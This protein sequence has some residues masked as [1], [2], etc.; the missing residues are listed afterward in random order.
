MGQTALFVYRC[1]RHE[2]AV[3]RASWHSDREAESA[4]T[5]RGRPRDRGRDSGRIQQR[6]HGSGRV[7]RDPR[8]SAFRCAGAASRARRRRRSV[9][10]RLHWDYRASAK[11][12]MQYLDNH[13]L[14]G[15]AALESG[16]VTGLR[17]LRVR[18][19]QGRDWRRVCDAGLNPEL[20][21]PSDGARARRAR[22]KRRC[23][24]TCLKPS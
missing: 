15:Y 18:G 21:P 13:M 16:Q 14:P 17:L 8:S 24:G 2:L 3:S 20:P 6:K 12:L 9:E 7:Y 4:R 10:E 1:V 23:S 5:T 11:L 22:S 19:N